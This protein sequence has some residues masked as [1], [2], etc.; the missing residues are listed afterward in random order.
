MTLRLF[1]RLALLMLLQGQMMQSYAQPFNF[2]DEKQP[3]F[4]IRPDFINREG[5]QFHLQL[6]DKNQKQIIP[7]EGLVQSHENLLWLSGLNE[8]SR[9]GSYFLLS[10]KV[11]FLSPSRVDYYTEEVITD[12]SFIQASM[13]GYKV[14]ALGSHHFKVDGT[15]FSPSFQFWMKVYN[16]DKE[17]PDAVAIMQYLEKNQPNLGKPAKIVV[18][19]NYNYGRVLMH[20]T[21]ENSVVLTLYY[22]WQHQKTLIVNYTVNLLHNIPPKFMGGPET[23][24][25]EMREGISNIVNLHKNNAAQ[26]QLTKSNP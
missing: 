1:Y 16:P 17:N 20:K 23:L 5:V 10:T 2:S 6:L 9:T 18:Q 11:A 3:D 21:T 24:K 19:K 13:E 26:R 14:H 7:A 8:S 15:L 12:P 4:S 22:P 25:N